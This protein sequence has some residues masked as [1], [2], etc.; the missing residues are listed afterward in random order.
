MS[1]IPLEEQVVD[2]ET[3]K[4]LQE[5]GFELEA[6]YWWYKHGDQ[7]DWQLGNENDSENYDWHNTKIPTYTLTEMLG[8]LPG[9]IDEDEFGQPFSDEDGE[10]YSYVLNNNSIGYWRPI[11]EGIPL[12]AINF[13][14]DKI[15]PATAAAKLGLW[16]KESGY[17][18][19][20]GGQ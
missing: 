19:G 12:K 8:G 3:A 17:I 20:K 6:N 16:L 9:E 4:L 5:A 2:K 11:D 7:N 10:I 13:T 14:L 15:N 18:G 1:N